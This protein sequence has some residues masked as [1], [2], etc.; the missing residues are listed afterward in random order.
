M[1]RFAPIARP[2]DLPGVKPLA[3]PEPAPA[4]AR[5]SSGPAEPSR[6]TPGAPL[7][8]DPAAPAVRVPRRSLP[9][10]PRAPG[11]AAGAA[12]AMLFALAAVTL[13]FPLTAQAQNATGE[14]AITG[15]ATVGQTLAVTQGT[16]ADP[17]GF[18]ANWF[19]NA[20]TTVQWIR[21]D[22]GTDSDISSA[23]GRTYTLVDD[24]LG[25]QIKVKVD[26]ADG[27]DNAES[28][29][30]AAFPSGDTVKAAELVGN[31]GQT[32]GTLLQAA[33]ISYHQAF[34]TGTNTSGYTL[35]SVEVRMYSSLNNNILT[36]LPEV[37]LYEIGTGLGTLLARLTTTTTSY[38]FGSATTRS[39]RPHPSISTCRPR[40]GFRYL[41]RLGAG[42]KTY[43]SRLP[44]RTTRTVPRPRAGV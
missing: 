12:L 35:T 40:T 38:T 26:F 28:R 14:P 25:K 6:G 2:S 31:V 36:F 11:A 43:R 41:G 8:P 7:S 20:T 3:L 19:S 30:S 1:I 16:I 24:D 10:R 21:V 18:P 4:R 17:Q 44:F 22:S 15:T 39:R 42:L 29:T 5:A 33:N 9:R 34:T 37:V 23:T 32:D 27:S 13:A